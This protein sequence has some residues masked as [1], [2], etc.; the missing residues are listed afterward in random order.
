[1]RLI[2]K[3]KKIG[4]D[5]NLVTDYEKY[6][7]IDFLD[8]MSVTLT[9][10]TTSVDWN[11]IFKKMY[12]IGYASVIPWISEI[13]HD[14]D[15]NMMIQSFDA[16]A[17]TFSNIQDFHRQIRHFIQNNEFVEDNIECAESNTYVLDDFS[18]GDF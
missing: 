2:K 17:L 11:I 9:K 6:S 8:M 5:F 13:W 3:R 10:D 18:S 4:L 16:C 14:F 15:E 1:M 12:L 7:I